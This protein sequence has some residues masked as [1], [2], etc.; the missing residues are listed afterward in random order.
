MIPGYNSAVV[1][2][3]QKTN[4]TNPKENGHATLRLLQQVLK[5]GKHSEKLP[6]WANTFYY[7]LTFSSAKHISWT[8]CTG[9][10]PNF[11]ER[12]ETV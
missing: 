4:P 6:V 7:T 5:I 12:T 3:S 1:W 10:F 9:A 2:N 8:T 11:G